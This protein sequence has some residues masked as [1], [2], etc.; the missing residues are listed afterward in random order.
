M[1]VKKQL[2]CKLQ[3]HYASSMVQ[4][5]VQDI[6]AAQACKE[7]HCA[8]EYAWNRLCLT[9]PRPRQGQASLRCVTG[10]VLTV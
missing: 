4:V 9:M 6:E 7:K 3:S 1:A 5:M 10:M 2:A 8:D